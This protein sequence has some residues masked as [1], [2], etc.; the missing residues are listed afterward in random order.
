M[1]I[2][3]NEKA[4]AWRAKVGKYASLAGIVVLLAAFVLSFTQPPSL[5]LMQA[6]LMAAMI[7]GVMLSF[8]GGYYGERFSGPLA[9]YLKVREALKGG[10]D[11]R[12]VLYQYVLP[13]SHVLLGPD[14]LTVFLVKAQGGKIAYRDGKWSHQQRGRFLRRLAGQEMVGVP[15]LEVETLVGRLNRYLEKRLPGVEVSVQGVVLFVNPDAEISVDDAP[16]PAFYGKKVRGWLR[17]PGARKNLSAETRRQI[18]EVLAGR[19]AET[20]E[21]E[22]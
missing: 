4:I 2:V 6:G 9:H 19:F 8:V 18:E 10:F 17:G 12:Y 5:V 3:E 14:G 15:H 7:V 22:Q 16:V 11:K 21:D 1:R 20:T 13:V